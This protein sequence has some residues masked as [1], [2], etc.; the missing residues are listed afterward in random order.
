[1]KRLLLT[2]IMTFMLMEMAAQATGYHTMQKLISPHAN[3]VTSNS[4]VKKETVSHLPN[5]T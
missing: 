5:L 2:A 1:M 3:A 4:S